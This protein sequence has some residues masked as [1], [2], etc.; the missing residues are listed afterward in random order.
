MSVK[1]DLNCYLLLYP[2]ATQARVQLPFKLLEVTRQLIDALF[3][4]EHVIAGWVV[5]A[6]QHFGDL[7]NL[8]P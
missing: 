6:F 3:E 4:R 2:S 8:G 1:Y 5:H 7:R